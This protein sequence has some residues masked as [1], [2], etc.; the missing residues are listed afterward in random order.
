[1][2]L[3]SQGVP[4]ILG[5][6]E[7]GRTQGGNNNAYCQDNPISWYDWNLDQE[8]LDLLAFTARAIGLRREHPVFRRGSFLTG[9]EPRPGSGVD[10][11]W[12]WTDGT[13]M[14]SDRWNSGSLAF[15]VWLNGAAL[16]DTDANGAPLTDDTFLILFNAS[17]NPQ[18]FTLPQPSRGPA[19][20]PV[21][22]ITQATGSPGPSSTALPTGSGYT[23]SPRS[24]LVL[25]RT[26]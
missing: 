8:R 4:M 11:A 12:L 23:L 24:L 7:I 21:L 19:W 13:P 18:V 5:G 9:Q 25:C 17:W 16:T 26:G 20:E 6:D 15:A 22:D 3:I 10:V 14:T 2:V 1:T